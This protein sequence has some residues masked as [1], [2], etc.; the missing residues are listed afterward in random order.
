MLDKESAARAAY[1]AYCEAVGGVA[2]NG[3]PLPTWEE[4]S[5]DPKKDKQAQGWRTAVAALGFE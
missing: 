3:D 5:Q 2:F 1:T 4:F